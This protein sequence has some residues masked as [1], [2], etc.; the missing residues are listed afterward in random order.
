MLASLD[1]LP[2]R[3]CDPVL[4]NKLKDMS[5]RYFL[6]SLSLKKREKYKEVVLLSWIGCAN[7]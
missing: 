5:L 4:P 7:G 6:G 2:T 3:L 1:S